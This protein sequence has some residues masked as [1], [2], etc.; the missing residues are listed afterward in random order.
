MLFKKKCHDTSRQTLREN[1][2]LINFSIQCK[3]YITV[4]N[5]IIIKKKKLSDLKHTL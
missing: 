2:N 1:K 5:P 4:R 3:A